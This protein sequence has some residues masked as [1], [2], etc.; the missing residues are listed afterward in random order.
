LS[1]LH[2]IVV[3]IVQGITEF[4]PISSSAHLI[5]TPVVFDWPDQ[6]PLIDVA[7][8]VGTLAAVVLYWRRDMIALLRG[9]VH[10]AR[11]RRTAEGRL[12][13]LLILATLPV[14]A[15]G[16]GLAE[17]GWSD[18]LRSVEVIAW[19]TVGFGVLLYAVDKVSMTVNRIE[20]MGAAGALLL[21]LAQVLALIPGTSRAGITITA[22]RML[23]F[24]RSEAARFSMLMAVPTIVAAGG[25]AG[26]ELAGAGQ[27]ALRAD[28]L[29]AGL[30]AFV[31]A[32]MAIA[33]MMRWL[34]NATYTPFV[35]YRI[36]LGAALFYWVYG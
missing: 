7:V 26:Y 25:Y 32:L 35:V 12:L 1:L 27:V 18:R 28:A 5:L 3:A 4:L 24:E 10:V 21:G 13:L 11:G 20:H 33:L 8:H 22:A 14:V 30:L 34:R 2:L 31:T 15:A 23:G 16:Y 36:V 17:S 9:A 29:I 19:A 6:G